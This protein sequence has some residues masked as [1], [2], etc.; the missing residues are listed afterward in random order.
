M[1]YNNGKKR[2]EANYKDGKHHGLLVMW[3]ANEQKM[4]EIKYEDGEEVEGSAKYWDK[5]EPLL[6][7]SE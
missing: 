1:W 3:Y 4:H 2:R 6:I 7:H 5:G